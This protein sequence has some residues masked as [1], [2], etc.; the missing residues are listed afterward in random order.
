MDHETSWFRLGPTDVGGC[1]HGSDGAP[2]QTPHL[3]GAAGRRFLSQRLTSSLGRGAGALD[4]SE[5][6]VA[7]RFYGRLKVISYLG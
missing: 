3:S 2:N 7:H 4:G 1:R 5:T 6:L